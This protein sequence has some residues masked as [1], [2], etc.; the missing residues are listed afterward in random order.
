MERENG[1]GRRQ[2]NDGHIAAE[3]IRVS[4]QLSNFDTMTPVQI[5]SPRPAHFQAPF[6]LAVTDPVIEAVLLLCDL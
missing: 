2:A 4:Q 5:F 1:F 6:L 3:T